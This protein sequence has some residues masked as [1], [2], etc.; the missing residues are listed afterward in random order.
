MW[1]EEMRHICS[2][3]AVEH[4][5]MLRYLTIIKHTHAADS[6]E[7]WLISMDGIFEVPA[8]RCEA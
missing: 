8:E 5:Y 1:E 6:N 3:V 4:K 2:T 7:I